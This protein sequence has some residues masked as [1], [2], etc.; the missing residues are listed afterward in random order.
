MGGTPITSRKPTAKAVRDMPDVRASSSSVHL[1]AG[2]RCML[3]SAAARGD[4]LLHNHQS[5]VLL[6]SD[7]DFHLLGAES[8]TTGGFAPVMR[9]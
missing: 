5:I 7:K 2:A 3:F 8:H 1:L 4:M 9:D 6:A